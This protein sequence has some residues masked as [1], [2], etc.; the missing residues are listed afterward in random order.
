MLF[1]HIS[2]IHFKAPECLNPDTDPDRGVRTRSER[3]LAA[4]IAKLGPESQRN[5]GRPIKYR[6]SLRPEL[7][8]SLAK[9]GLSRASHTNASIRS[10]PSQFSAVSIND[11]DIH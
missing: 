3:H 1:L 11:N 9:L 2:D 7:L 10:F 6:M 8:G 4:E 5:P